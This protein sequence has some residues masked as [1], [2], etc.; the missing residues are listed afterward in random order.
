MEYLILLIV[1][2]ILVLV[3]TQISTTNVIKGGNSNTSN[4]VDFNKKTEQM[5]HYNKLEKYIR[6][7]G[8]P[9]SNTSLKHL[10]DN[11]HRYWIYIENDGNISGFLYFNLKDAIDVEFLWVD[12][13]SR[14]QGIGRKLFNILIEFRNKNHPKIPIKLDADFTALGYYLKMDGFHIDLNNVKKHHPE[15][16]NKRLIN[17][18]TDIK[19]NAKLFS[20]LEQISHDKN[21]PMIYK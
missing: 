19:K 18:E 12:P 20:E 1:F 15:I 7:Y 6:K 4:I 13:L 5:E 16:D 2:I 11:T 17:I 9:E 3:L 21:I 14:R 10:L 8:E